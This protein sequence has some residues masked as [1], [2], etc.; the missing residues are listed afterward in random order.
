[1]VGQQSVRACKKGWR[2]S[3]KW[4]GQPIWRF[5]TLSWQELAAAADTKNA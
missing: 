1:M 2:V 5:S 4:K 3:W